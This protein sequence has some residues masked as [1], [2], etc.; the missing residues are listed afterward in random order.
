MIDQLSIAVQLPCT[1]EPTRR[2][3]V[4]DVQCSPAPGTAMIDNRVLG[5]VAIAFAGV[6]FG[7]ATGRF[8]AWLV[9]PSGPASVSSAAK[10]SV[11]LAPTTVAKEADRRPPKPL[12][13][14]SSI[15]I[16]DPPK[17]VDPGNVQKAAHTP[18]ESKE[19]AVPDSPKPAPE[20][21]S[22]ALSPGESQGGPTRPDARVINAGS[23]DRPEPQEQATANTGRDLRTLTASPDA[24]EA[25]RRKFR[26]FDPTDGTY[27]PYGQDT[28]IPCPHLR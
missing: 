12:E 18:A 20:V 16:V 27:K 17:A 24:L 9:P 28:R 13:S 25:C 21:T 1:V 26:S 19:A 23:A 4:L 22:R 10:P 11:P 2:S 3:V 14:T 5:A 6:L 7:F 8:S 15:V